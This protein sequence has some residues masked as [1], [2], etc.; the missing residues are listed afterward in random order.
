MM[1][2]LLA[3]KRSLFEF[4]N[5]VVFTK[6]NSRLNQASKEQFFA[7]TVERSCPEVFCEKG[8]LKHFAKFIGK[9][10]CPSLFLIRFHA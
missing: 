1:P 8:V 7:G 2:T 5:Y 3:A 10:L 6:T 9:H 4:K